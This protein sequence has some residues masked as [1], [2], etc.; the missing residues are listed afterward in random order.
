MFWPPDEESVMT[1]TGLG[2]GMEVRAGN[3]GLYHIRPTCLSA[4]EPWV[5]DG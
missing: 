2:M 1:E 5:A 4:P 3:R